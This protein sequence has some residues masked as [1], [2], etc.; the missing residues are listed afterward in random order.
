MKLD[1]G[2]VFADF[3][4]DIVHGQNIVMKSDGS[5][6][7]P[8]CYLADATVAFFTVLL[9]GD[10]G[11]PYNVGNDKSEVSII[12]LAN[13]LVRLFP[14]KALKVIRQ[15]HTPGYLKSKVSRNCP[16]IA[17]IRALGWEPVTTIE[18]GFRRTIRSYQ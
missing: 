10:D 14:E 6:V 15:E 13:M 11:Q 17:K 12:E 7:R 8:F 2:R 9:R 3:V 4:A 5:A 16:D 18:E 1:D